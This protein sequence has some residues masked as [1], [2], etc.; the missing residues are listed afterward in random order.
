MVVC[1]LVVICCLR[2]CLVYCMDDACVCGLTDCGVCLVIWYGSV[3][4]FMLI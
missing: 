3:R 4:R 1:C 2:D